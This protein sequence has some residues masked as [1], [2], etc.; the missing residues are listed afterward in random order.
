MASATMH[1][2]FAGA[3]LRGARAAFG[4]R[5]PVAPSRG[6]LVIVAGYNNMVKLG[7]GK[8][9]E[10]QELTPN[11][12]PV[13]TPMH[14]KKG[15][16]VQVIAGEDKGAVGEIEKVLTKKGLVVVKGVNI[17]P[18][19]RDEQGQQKRVESPIHHSNVM[20]YSQEKAVRSRIGFKVTAD[21]KKV[22]YLL[23]T[24]EEVPERSFDKTPKDKKEEGGD[25]SG[26]AAPS[27]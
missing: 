16:V 11:G 25:A 3:S 15:D 5:A 22:R 13:K 23:K 14:V 9:W 6:G 27:A 24:G 19:S 7:G 10:R 21:G 4:A 12:K 20:H 17:K 18:R 1:S 26:P 8:K 2:S